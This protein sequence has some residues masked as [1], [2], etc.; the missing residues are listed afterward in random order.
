MKVTNIAMAMILGLAAT[1]AFAC[2]KGTHPVGG[3]GPHHKGGKCV[4]A[5]EAKAATPDTDAAADTKTTKKQK[6]KAKK[7]DAAK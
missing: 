7:I 6:G 4:G 2:P 5:S 3:T 1:T